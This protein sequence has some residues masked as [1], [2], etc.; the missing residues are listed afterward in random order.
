MKHSLLLSH[1]DTKRGDLAVSL[2]AGTLKKIQLMLN[3]TT[4][5]TYH[6]ASWELYM[7]YAWWSTPRVTLHEKNN[8][9]G[10]WELLIR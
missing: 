4:P 5:E 8:K 1:F 3:Q 7:I 9:H 6:G 2:S 10:S